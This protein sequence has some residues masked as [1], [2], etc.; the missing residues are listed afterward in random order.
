[1]FVLIKDIAGRCIIGLHECLYDLGG[2][3]VIQL[4]NIL[5]HKLVNIN[6]LNTVVNLFKCS[7]PITVN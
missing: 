7:N 5:I 6:K 1:M 3:K 2:G 4:L